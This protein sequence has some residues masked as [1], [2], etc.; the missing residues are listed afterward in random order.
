MSEGLRCCWT[1]CEIYLEIIKEREG[2]LNIPEVINDS[3]RTLRYHS[4][5]Y[6][7]KSDFSNSRSFW[8]QNEAITKRGRATVKVEALC[9]G[10]LSACEFME[11][12]E[13]SWIRFLSRLKW[14][15][16]RKDE[17][18]EANTKFIGVKFVKEDVV[19]ISFT[20]ISGEELQVA[21]H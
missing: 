4:R 11:H 1:H 15:P 2:R 18:V 3:E 7:S 12:K 21:T 10:H 17:K 8:S 16:K 14:N 13:S 20:V 19:L 6:P 9:L 5:T